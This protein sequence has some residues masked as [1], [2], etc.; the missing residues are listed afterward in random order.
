M[1]GVAVVELANHDDRELAESDP[2]RALVRRRICTT[3]RE[4]RFEQ[5]SIQ[6]PRSIEMRRDCEDDFLIGGNNW[7]GC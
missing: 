7:N 2:K 6:L 4:A 1:L 5:N 3:S